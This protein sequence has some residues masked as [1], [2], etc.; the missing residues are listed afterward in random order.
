MSTDPGTHQDA[1][2]LTLQRNFFNLWKRVVA[3]QTLGPDGMPTLTSKD[4][5]RPEVKTIV[6]SAGARW[7]RLVIPRG[8]YVWTPD[9]RQIDYLPGHHPGDLSANTA[10]PWLKATGGTAKLWIPGEWHLKTPLEDGD[11]EGDKIPLLVSEAPSGFAGLDV[12][13]EAL[14]GSGAGGALKFDAP[15]V[16]PDIDMVSLAIATAPF[17][18]AFIQNTSSA[19]QTLW[20]GIGHAAVIGRGIPLYSGE[21]YETPPSGSG[22]WLKIAQRIF[23]ISDANDGSA[24]I[25]I[26]R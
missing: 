16:I 3:P 7:T 20:L 14:T 25:Q 11:T 8:M 9:F 19:G 12:S 26:A 6:A 21:W 5:K 4:V 17:R 23:V 1:E 18:Y 2:L 22:G 15:D 13:A 24:T 10:K